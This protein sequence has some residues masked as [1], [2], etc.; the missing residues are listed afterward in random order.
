MSADLPIVALLGNPNCGKTTIFNALTGARQHVGNYPGVT[1]ESKTGVLRL[2]GGNVK[3]VDLPG[4]YRLGGNSPEERVVTETLSSGRVQVIVNVVDS[5]HLDRNLYV[6]LQLWHFNLPVVLVLNMS[7]EAEAAGIDF[8]VELLEKLLGV[9]V[10][11]TSGNKGE[12]IAA[13]K[14]AVRQAVSHPRLFPRLKPVLYGERQDNALTELA[15]MLANAPCNRDHEPDTFIAEKLLEG[16]DEFTTRMESR[17]ECGLAICEKARGLRHEISSEAGMPVAVLLADK[18][19]GAI[20]GLTRAVQIS[21]RNRQLFWTDRIDAVATHP[22]MGIPLFLAAMYL[23]FY[24]TFTLGD[25]LVGAMENLFSWLGGLVAGWTSASPILQSLLCDGVIGG[26]GGVLSFVPTILILFLCLAVLEASGYMARAAFIMDRFMHKMGLHGKSF[27]PML[28]GFGCTV[29]AVM[30]TRSI[31]SKSDRFAT[32][33]ILPLMSCGA[34][35]PIFVLFISALFRDSMQAE[36]LWCL[37]LLGIVVAVCTAR[38]LKSTLFKGN[39]EL[40]LLELPPY[41][42][43]SLKNLLLLMIQR[44][45][46]YLKKA[47]TII[48]FASMV[49]W[50]LNTY[51]KEDSS[52]GAGYPAYASLDSADAPAVAKEPVQAS[53]VDSYSSRIGRFFEP[54]T[55]WAGMDWKT[56]SALIGAFAAKEI[57]VS[58]L[59]ILYSAGEDGEPPGENQALTKAIQEHYTP[60][61]GL[62]IMIFCLIAMPCMATFGVV[63]KET[64]SWGFAVGQSL[65]LDVLGLALA[66]LVYQGGLL[67]M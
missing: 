51:P 37:Y 42:M 21:N 11:R 16:D 15:G 44:A 65:F 7:D 20:S 50:F 43:P 6:T 4:I 17:G 3:L 22:L 8:D 41:R 58:Q 45:W 54:L 29:P 56:N 25:P 19:Y 40:F 34:R 13:L 52:D 38:L 5:T 10:I 27:I 12:G 57:F 46:M 14:R 64:G 2:T 31:E 39:D 30:A 23:V 47:G 53:P 55:M 66:I 1:V 9:R 49:L 24:M 62:A 59:G 28:I 32:I 67:L 33:F 48:L 18:R 35:L 61:Q 36:I 63:K 26:V 60:L